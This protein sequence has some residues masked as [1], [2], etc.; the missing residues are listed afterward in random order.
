MSVVHSSMQDW[1]MDHGTRDSGPSQDRTRNVVHQRCDE[2]DHR[3]FVFFLCPFNESVVISFNHRRYTY[4][5]F[6]LES[7]TQE[8]VEQQ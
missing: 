6:Y 1:I 8:N 3:N 7:N 4:S 5:R 2:D